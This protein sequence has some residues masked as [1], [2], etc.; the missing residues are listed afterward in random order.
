MGK[1]RSSAA[2]RRRPYQPPKLDNKN[3]N[4][5]ICNCPFKPVTCYPVSK[6]S[7]WVLECCNCGERFA[8]P[9]QSPMEPIDVYY[10][11]VDKC[12]A[13]KAQSRARER[14]NIRAQIVDALQVEGMEHM[15]DEAVVAA[16]QVPSRSESTTA[17]RL[18]RFQQ[19]L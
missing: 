16:H 5:P 15:R 11:W 9:I 1:R 3:F 7:L 19:E 10:R 18:T 6:E 13:A 4:C 12:E 17:P 2:V 14:N 8:A